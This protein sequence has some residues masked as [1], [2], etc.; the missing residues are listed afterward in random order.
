MQKNYTITLDDDPIIHKIIGR[1][2]GINSLPFVC[3]DKLLS[4]AR[5]Y[6]PAAVFIDV[7]IDVNVCG[8]DY[9][10][11]LRKIW[12]FIPILVVTDD[13]TGELVGRALASGANDFVRKPLDGVELVGRLRAR[14]NEMRSR[15]AAN[16]VELSDVSFSRTS[17]EL[18]CRGKREPL[19]ILESRLFLALAESPGMPIPKD[20]LKTEL[21]GNTH[22]SANALD[23]KVSTLRGVL[24]RI[25]A[26]LEIRSVYGGGVLLSTDHQNPEI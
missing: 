1:M 16:V 4:R 7:H 13:P 24:K 6:E 20:I 8:L 3:P 22:V 11:A 14:I 12:P 5:S 17:Q 21:W 23:K 15:Q 9:V 2:T 18:E 26:S 10:P 19:P 25:G